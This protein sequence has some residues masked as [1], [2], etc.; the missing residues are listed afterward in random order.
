MSKPLFIW[1][2]GKNKMLKHYSSLMPERVE[3]YVEPFFGGGAMYIYIVKNYNPKNLYIN[4]INSDIIRIYNSIKNNLDEFLIKLDVLSETYLPLDY[5]GRR[6]YFFDIRNQHA[7]DYENWSPAEEAATLY[8]LMKTGFNGVFQINQNTN[9]RYGT[10]AGL[11]NHKDKVYDLEVV[12]WWHCALQKTNIL[13]M[14][15]K[16]CLSSIHDK[17]DTFI[18]LDPPYRGSFTSYGQ[19]F[20]DNEQEY[21][22]NFVKSAHK[23]LVFLCN[24]DV[25]DNFFEERLEDLQLEK[26]PITYTAGRRKKTETGF[27]A[28]KATEILIHNKF[29]L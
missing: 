14:D 19:D 10:P 15:Y 24:R 23:S 21:L 7:F 13:S 1:A 26:F 17:E 8:F 9:N 22:I 5:E 2:G 20:Q 11:L 27:E 16:D 18:F 28:K 4:D 6:S 3:T 12:K 29:L 25:D